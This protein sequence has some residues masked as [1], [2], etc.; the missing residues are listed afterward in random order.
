[1]QEG[2]Y[3]TFKEAADTAGL[4]LSAWVR[5]RLKKAARNEMRA[6]KGGR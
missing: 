1:M 4:D 6:A 3:A 2:E 5:E